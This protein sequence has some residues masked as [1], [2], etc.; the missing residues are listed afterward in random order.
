[1]NNVCLYFLCKDKRWNWQLEMMI[2]SFNWAVWLT[3]SLQC[4]WDNRKLLLFWS[5]KQTSKHQITNYKAQTFLYVFLLPSNKMVKRILLDTHSIQSLLWS[6][7]PIL[8]SASKHFFGV[9]LIFWA[10]QKLTPEGRDKIKKFFRSFFPS[11]DIGLSISLDLQMTEDLRSNISKVLV[12]NTLEK[13][14]DTSFAWGSHK[15]QDWCTTE[16]GI[17]TDN[18][19]EEM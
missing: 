3:Y 17:R 15:Q 13:Y 5:W 12:E 2:C 18:A 7:T 16:G 19:W 14:L 10:R 8:L 9:V 6:S 11:L 1:M 4:S